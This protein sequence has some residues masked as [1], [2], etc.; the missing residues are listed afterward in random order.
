MR[1]G[2]SEAFEKGYQEGKTSMLLARG[3]EIARLK[4][5]LEEAMEIGRYLLSVCDDGGFDED[6]F[7]RARA[8]LNKTGK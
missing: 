7:R 4:A 8:F 5:E 2:Q 1:K 6:E 3:A